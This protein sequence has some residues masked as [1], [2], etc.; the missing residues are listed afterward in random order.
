M[1]LPAELQGSATS[2]LISSWAGTD[3]KAAAEWA[4][5]LPESDSR[6]EAI[7]TL[8]S[9]W[10]AAEPAN[11]LAWVSHLPDSPEQRE[12]LD[13]SVR[14]W[15]E[16]DPADLGKWVNQ[17]PPN[18]T[19]DHLRSV[20][21]LVLVESQPQDAMAMVMKISD[22][23]TRDP[24]LTQLLKRWGRED[25]AAAKAWAGKNGFAERLSTPPPS[26]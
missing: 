19:T 14:A 7:S 20:A 13:D 6:N 10:S 22:P 23:A 9:A 11:A 1:K 5:R 24:A 16:L 25:A 18:A 15:T 26:E 4:A 21:A 17:Q 3:P 8:A 2:T 12:A